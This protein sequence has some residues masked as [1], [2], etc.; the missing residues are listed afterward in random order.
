MTRCSISYATIMRKINDNWTFRDFQKKYGCTEEELKCHIRNLCRRE[1][2]ATKLIRRIARN[3]EE[4]MAKKTT[5]QR[6]NVVGQ[7][8]EKG[9]DCEMA[10]KEIMETAK[11]LENRPDVPEIG[12][13]KPET[14]EAIKE[15]EDSTSNM[16]KKFEDEGSS[17]DSLTVKKSEL[18]VRL[19]SLRKD[20]NNKAREQGRL[21]ALIAKHK[22]RVDELE[23]E[24]AGLEAEQE[25]IALMIDEITDKIAYV[26]RVF[27][28]VTSAGIELYEAVTEVCLD[29]SGWDSGIFNDVSEDPRYD[30]RRSEYNLLKRA[31]SIAI[32]SRRVFGPTIDVVSDIEEFEDAFHSFLIE[33]DD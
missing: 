32:N 27:I 5:Q 30:F 4:E 26:N 22:S 33:F 25:E 15:L 3:E 29:D 9:K 21:K 20:R 24:I 10:K 28:S 7:T 17:L 18:Q 16:I 1:H 14:A 11:A 19:D 8:S 2:H 23:A 31:L 13:M 12:E 6:K